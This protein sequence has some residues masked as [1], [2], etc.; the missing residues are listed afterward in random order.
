MY[1]ATALTLAPAQSPGAGG[2]QEAEGGDGR[3][4]EAPIPDQAVF[5]RVIGM[6]RDYSDVLK[7][8]TRNLGFGSDYDSFRSMSE[9][10]GA[11]SW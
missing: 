5:R 8:R 11:M 3:E 1:H 10:N 6:L 4:Y 9:P 2:E 7:Q